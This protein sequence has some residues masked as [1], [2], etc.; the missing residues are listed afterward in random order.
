M[1][2][3]SGAF[4]AAEKFFPNDTDTKFVKN[5]FAAQ[6]GDFEMA[7]LQKAI[8]ADR[9][10]TNVQLVQMNGENYF[11]V[12]NKSVKS[13]E[14]K[15]N[16][17][18]KGK[19]LM[20]SQ[21]VPPPSTVYVKASDYSVL[22]NGE[23]RYANYLAS[24]ISQHRLEDIVKTEVITK[25]E[26]EYGFVNKRLPVWKVSFPTNSQERFYVETSTGKLAA[27]VNDKDLIEGFSFAFLHKHHFLDFAGKEA[28]DLSTMFWAAAQIVMV[29]IG[30]IF[31][32]RLRK[33]Q[34]V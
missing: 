32:N 28:R 10:L 1:F 21:T 3:L 12:S 24:Q 29:I 13:G 8:G 7:K 31:W 22:L 5:T 2:T 19:D 15:K 11:Q 18:E 20:K 16:E 23:E 30:F 26:G 6:A 4:H 25:F 34:T 27:H 33:T 17:G 14:M 9:F